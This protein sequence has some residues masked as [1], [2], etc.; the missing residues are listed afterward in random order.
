M[1]RATVAGRS[2]AV[3]SI[4]AVSLWLGGLVA[5]GAIAAPVVFSV[6][7]PPANATA[8]T[9]V[10]RRF[11]L[12]AMASAAVLLATEAARHLVRGRS[13]PLD[14]ARGATAALA[15]AFA[16]VQGTRI[17]PRIAELHFAGVSRGVGDSGLKLSH[18]H[19]LAERC[20]KAQLVLLTI[21][22][23]LQIFT[24]P[25]RGRGASDRTETEEQER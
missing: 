16:V 12:I 15:S 11:D 1:D 9:I 3:V 2:L 17:S 14:V 5:L 19:D 8:M 4:L 13:N 6:I 7:L 24:L 18:L 20:G 22:V 25:P 21:F 10:F 23:A